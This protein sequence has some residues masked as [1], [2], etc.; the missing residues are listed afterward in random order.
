MRWPARYAAAAAAY[1]AEDA[2][3]AGP[4]GLAVRAHD[5]PRRADRPRLLPPLPAGMSPCCAGRGLA[6][7]GT[8]ERLNPLAGAAR[9]RWGVPWSRGICWAAPRLRR[10]WPSP[11]WP[12][13][14]AV[15]V[16][17]RQ[18]RPRESLSIYERLVAQAAPCAGPA[19]Q[20]LGAAVIIPEVAPQGR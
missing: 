6:A 1:R 7:A 9:R 11:R 17:R 18:R 10:S 3:L 20:A 4:H 8:V 15:I 14:S 13:V 5:R 12:T 16:R 2:A 19:L